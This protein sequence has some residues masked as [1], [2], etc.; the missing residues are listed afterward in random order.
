MKR[1]FERAKKEAWRILEKHPQADLRASELREL[2]TKYSGQDPTESIY[3]AIT[4]VWYAAFFFG[5]RMGKADA[6]AQ[7]DV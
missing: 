7:E 3:N 5:Y 4:D 1:N 6:D 2:I